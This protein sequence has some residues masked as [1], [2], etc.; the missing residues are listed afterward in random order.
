[1]K[2]LVILMGTILLGTVIF[3]MMTGDQP[4]SLKSTASDV[5]RTSLEQYAQEGSGN[6]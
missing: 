3:H 1:M 6:W 2:N 5:M 4:G